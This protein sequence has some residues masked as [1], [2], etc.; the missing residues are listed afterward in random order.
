MGFNPHILGIYGSPREGGNTDILLDAF[1][2]A[3]LEEGATTEKV[4]P[5][6]LDIRYCIEC[7]QCEKVGHCVVDDDMRQIFP[8]LESAGAV[9][10]ASPIFFYTVTG[11]VK[12]VIDRSQA[13]W[14]RKY[15]LNNPVPAIVDGIERMGYFI[16]C[17]AT[18]GGNLFD[19][20][21]LTM[22]YFFDA[23]GVRQGESLTYRRVENKGDIRKL[24]GALEEA[25]ALGRTAGK[26]VL[27]KE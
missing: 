12:P 15:V 4:Y 9:V 27:G 26:R 13:L 22:K 23:V 3:A 11:C 2:S 24:P 1:L 8:L 17:G 16:S 25:E 19:G 18:K 7:R 10:L 20:S 5:R 14:A 6:K 21:L